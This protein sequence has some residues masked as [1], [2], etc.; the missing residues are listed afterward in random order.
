MSVLVCQ[1]LF[2]VRLL[3]LCRSLALFLQRASVIERP[4]S[5]SLSL[6]LSVCLALALS[7]PLALSFCVSLLLVVSFFL[8]LSWSIFCLSLL[9]SLSLA[10]AQRFIYS[11]FTKAIHLFHVYKRHVRWEGTSQ[12]H[13]STC[14]TLMLLNST[15]NSPFAAGWYPQLFANFIVKKTFEKLLSP[16]HNSGIL[17]RQYWTNQ[18]IKNCE[19]IKKNYKRRSEKK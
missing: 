14:D 16:I 10:F 17:G 15:K 11:V 7:T 8:S 18:K 13:K 3:S 6:S 5:V 4:L 12:R 2:L 19:N 1:S 9:F